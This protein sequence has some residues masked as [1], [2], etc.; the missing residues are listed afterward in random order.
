[1]PALPDSPSKSDSNI[2]HLRL[3]VILRILP[4]MCPRTMSIIPSMG[5]V[6]DKL[7]VITASLLL[8]VP[9]FAYQVALKDGRVIQFQKYRVAD[10][11]LYYSA[12]DGREA[13]IPLA[14]VDMDRTRQLNASESPP[15]ELPGLAPP[16]T[17]A[18]SQEPSLGEIARQIRRGQTKPATKRVFTD[19]DVAHATYESLTASNGAAS[20]IEQT[21]AY[22]DDAEAYANELADK[23]ARQL[24]DLAVGDVQFPGRDRWEDTLFTQKEE[25]VKAIRAAVFAARQRMHLLSLSEG[26]ASPSKDDQVKTQEAKRAVDEQISNIRLQRFRYD[27][28]VSEGVRAAAEWKRR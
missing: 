23:T 19:D 22:L 10:D 16:K 6:M 21:N 13:S 24:A 20:S 5:R 27:Q 3:G 7:I 15:L 18:V 9:L 28:L 26:T 11:K 12:K 14:A 17:P 2:P 4:F 8:G 1:M 25:L